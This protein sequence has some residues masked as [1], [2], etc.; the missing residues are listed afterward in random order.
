MEFNKNTYIYLFGINSFTI[1]I[2]LFKLDWCENVGLWNGAEID[3]ESRFLWVY[4]R[5]Y[6]T[7]ASSSFP[8]TI[9]Q[10]R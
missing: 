10:W 2:I 9:N 3:A 5:K 4:I 8:I 1:Y 6:E 7:I